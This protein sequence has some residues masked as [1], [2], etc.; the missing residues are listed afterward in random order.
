VTDVIGYRDQRLAIHWIKENIA[1]F[2]GDPDKVTIWGESAGAQ[3][4]AAHL[5]AYGG[6]TLK[7]LYQPREKKIK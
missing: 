5:L 1:A 4:V 3:S 7:Y 2:G 6:T